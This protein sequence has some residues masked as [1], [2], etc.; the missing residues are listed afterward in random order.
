MKNICQYGKIIIAEATL[1]PPFYKEL[2]E[3]QCNRDVEVFWRN[4]LCHNSS[5]YSQTPFPEDY[6]AKQVKQQ[7][8]KTL[9]G[10]SQF[11]QLPVVNQTTNLMLLWLKTNATEKLMI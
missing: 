9:Y 1:R 2:K 11:T 6:I 8:K 5:V 10:R 7:E 3:G 4:P